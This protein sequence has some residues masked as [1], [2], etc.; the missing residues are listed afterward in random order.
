MQDDIIT[1]RDNRRLI[2]ARK[3]RDGKVRELIFLEGR[4][5]VGEALRSE[6][7]L[8]ECFAADSFDD[9]EL[10][11]KIASR[12]DVRRVA[13]N[14]FRSITD[15]ES[16]QGIALI[17][18]RPGSTLAALDVGSA[19]VPVVVFL[20]EA[21]NP[22]NLGA[23]FRTAEAAGIA[24]VIVSEN[25]ADAFSPKANRAAMGA[26]LRLPVVEGVSFEAA[27]DWARD[28]G[29]AA[30]AT[31]ASGAVRYDDLDWTKPRLLVLGSEARGLSG[32]ELADVDE[33]VTIPMADGVESL[34][35]GVAAGILLFE[36]RRQAGFNAKTQSGTLLSDI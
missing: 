2:D 21:N 27:L 31:G 29:L 16:P 25:S 34:N 13:D 17:A 18:Q 12:C 6:I 1:S 36:A 8:A 35:L 22:S 26:N 20:K 24:G 9:G 19:D 3:V 10:L 5:L 23:I 33:T 30:T 14:S 7:E 32:R 4:R 28:N 15:T 11:A